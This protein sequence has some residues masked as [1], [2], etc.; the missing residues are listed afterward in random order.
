[1]YTFRMGKRQG[2]TAFSPFSA[3]TRRWLLP[4]MLLV[5]MMTSCS[6]VPEEMLAEEAAE[7]T[8]SVILSYATYTV[9]LPEQA[10][11]TLESPMISLYN[12]SR[13]VRVEMPSFTHEK[14]EGSLVHGSALTGRYDADSKALTLTGNVILDDDDLGLNLSAHQLNWLLDVQQVVSADPVTIGFGSGSTINGSSLSGNLES[15][16]FVLTD[17]EGWIVP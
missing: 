4:V 5:A 17:A 3:I 11:M 12:N 9:A 6:F 1:M 15:G 8:P 10:P 13:A 7:G 14:S 16:R 2:Q